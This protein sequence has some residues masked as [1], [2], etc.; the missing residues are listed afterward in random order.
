VS[1]NPVDLVQ[2]ILAFTEGRAVLAAGARQVAIRE[3]A[4]VLCPLVLAGED[5]ALHAVAVGGLGQPPAIRVVPDPRDRAAQAALLGVVA[6]YLEAYFRSCR[7]DGG[8]PQL[9]VPSRAA[10]DQ[11]SLLADRYRFARADA[12]TRRLGQLLTYPAERATHAGQQCLLAATAALRQHWATGQDPGAGEHLGVA[13][14]WIAPSP[15]RPLAEVV[16]EVERLPAGVKTDPEFDRRV[17]YPLVD[18]FGKAR[19]RG[20]PRAELQARAREIRAE[21][22][23]VVGRIYRW[24]QEAVA[25]LDAL[26]LPDL[27]DLAEL[28]RREAD[29]FAFFLAGLDGG[30]VIGTRDTPRAAAH[31]FAAREDAAQNVAAALRLGDPVERARG[32]LDGRIVR[33]VVRNRRS[34]RVGRRRVIERFAVLTDQRVLHARVRDALLLADDPRL[35]LEVREVRRGAEGTVLDLEVTRGQRSVPLP[36]DGDTVELAEAAPDWGLLGRTRG[37]LADRLAVLPWTHTADPLPPPRPAQVV[38]D[39]AA[40]LDEIEGRR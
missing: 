5:V 17:L 33:G 35:R 13:L 10:A 28:E 40:L 21:L 26:P 31:R 12:G 8:F 4:R 9:W 19:R 7:R 24:T 27:P 6:R 23:S 25:L 30:Y 15:G 3:D 34:D 16:A 22:E 38:P 29:A 39:G 32:L 36:V 37:K 14:A 18:A 1:S 20:A 11:L 2:A